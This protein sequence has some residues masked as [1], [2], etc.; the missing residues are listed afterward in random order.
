MTLREFYA[1]LDSNYEQIL[2]RLPSEAMIL[3]F[4]KMYADDPCVRLLTENIERGDWSEA[5]RAAH[6]LKGVALNLGFDH[7]QKYASE[8]TELLRPEQPIADNALVDAV[9]RE[10]EKILA[11]LSELEVAQTV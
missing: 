4:V 2:R 9:C 3:K 5:F 6:T 7:L 1:Q 10:H 8:L 11:A